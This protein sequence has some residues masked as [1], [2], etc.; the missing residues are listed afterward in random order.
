MKTM[1]RG[2]ID[3][4][5]HSSFSS[6]GAVAPADLVN[7][8]RAAGLGA[9]A[10]TDHDTV[11]GLGQFTYAARRTDVEV[12]PGI[13][14][15]VDYDGGYLHILG[16]F[17]DRR[18]PALEEVINEL[19]EARRAQAAGRIGK[20]RGL[21]LVVDEELVKHYARGLAPVGPVI[22]MAVLERPKNRKH[23][24]LA[25]LFE[26]PK[27]AAPYFHFDRDLLAEGKPA[28]FPVKRPT[29]GE[30]AE[31]IRAAGGIPILAHPG[32]RF[33]LPADG[34]RIMEL[35]RAGIAGLE[36]YST[37]HNPEEE[38]AF[39]CFARENSL[40]ATAGS[41]FHG[42]P[43]KPGVK[44][45]GITNNDYSLLADLREL[46]EKERYPGVLG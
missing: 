7:M 18:A 15:T 9:V 39:A 12:V 27:S 14:L 8:A 46:W 21:G 24:L 35:I 26:P 13:E 19:A 25:E 3:L 5:V 42:S 38:R 23:P 34:G 32:D 11:D 37:Y 17:I 45:G 20:L 31:V 2:P 33:S 6:D 36:V 43:V 4:H 29:P 22:G 44:L 41:D 10:L 28:H 40:A 16:Y 1:T 30:A